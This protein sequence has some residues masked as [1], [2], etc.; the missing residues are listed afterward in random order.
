MRRRRR[1]EVINSVTVRMMEKR[2]EPWMEQWMM[3][4]WIS[5]NQIAAGESVD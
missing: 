1:K 3:E 2:M 5:Q 4:Q